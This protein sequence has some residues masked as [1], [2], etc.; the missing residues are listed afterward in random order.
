L[1]GSSLESAIISGASGFIGGAVTGALLFPPPLISPMGAGAIGGAVSGF[2]SS[3]ATEIV[4]ILRSTGKAPI[5]CIERIALNITVG[6]TAGILFGLAGGKTS[7]L[8]SKAIPHTILT[9]RN[10]RLVF[11]AEVSIEDTVE[12]T[13]TNIA[14]GI[15]ARSASV[16]MDAANAG[17]DTSE[18]IFQKRNRI[19]KEM[20]ETEHSFKRKPTN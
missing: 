9:G 15:A 5:V 7:E 20:I 3:S 8:S 10:F 14:V 12:C 16:T 19:L 4:R 1:T 17:I 11:G 6:T 18:S 2:I 13:I